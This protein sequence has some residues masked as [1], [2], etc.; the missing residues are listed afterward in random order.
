MQHFDKRELNW[1]TPKCGIRK[2]LSLLTIDNSI[3]AL[4]E[5]ETLHLNTAVSEKIPLRVWKLNCH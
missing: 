1:M 3:N 4:D 5:L 2:K